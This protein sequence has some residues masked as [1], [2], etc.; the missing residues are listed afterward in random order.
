MK[1]VPFIALL[2]GLISITGC[3]YDNEEYLYPTPVN[4]SCDTTTV[5]YSQRLVPILDNN[6]CL[7][8][9]N[10]S[11]ASGGI[12]LEGHA[13]VAANIDSIIGAISHA[14]GFTPMP[15]GASDP[16]PAC[17]IAAFV[18]WKN[19]GSNDN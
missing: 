2:L 13:N 17:D 6:Q 3:Y 5:S 10:N 7:S 8:C 18:A 12:N 4:T 11:L 15:Q 14:Q 16:L 9:H 1:Y 19:H